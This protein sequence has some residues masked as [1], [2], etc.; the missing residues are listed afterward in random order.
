MLAEDAAAAAAGCAADV[1]LDPT[2][3]LLRV[4]PVLGEDTAVVDVVVAAAGAGGFADSSKKALT[5][6][7]TGELPFFRSREGEVTAAADFGT[8][9]FDEEPV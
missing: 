8:T 2:S 3:V 6:S 5:D 4:W 7:S 1:P 9:T